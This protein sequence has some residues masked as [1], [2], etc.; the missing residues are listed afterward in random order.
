MDAKYVV[1]S[2]EPQRAADAIA[3]GQSIGNPDK[4]AKYETEKMWK[5][6]GAQ[7]TDIEST[8]DSN[9]I[10]TINYPN[11]IFTPGSLTHLLTV[12][13]GGQMDID[14]I[15]KCVLVELTFDEEIVSPYVGPKFGVNKVRESIEITERPMIGGIVK[16]KTGLDEDTLKKIVEEMIDGGVDFIKEDEILGEI[17]GLTFLKRIKFIDKLI[18]KKKSN[19]IYAPALN[20]SMSQLDN[21]IKELNRM[22]HIKAFHF[23]VWGGLDLFKYISDNTTKMS[24]YQKSG[25]KVITSGKFS[26][27]FEIWCVLCRLAGADMMHAGMVGGYLDEPVKLMKDRIQNM[28][29]EFYSLNGVIPSMSCG[30]HPGLVKYLNNLFGNNI[31]I[32]SGGAIHAHKDGTFAGTKSFLDAAKGITSKELDIAIEQ[33]GLKK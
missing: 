29:G 26:V 28:Q 31:M 20:V 3:V 10:V 23:N 24:F 16:P 25:D 33:F 22:E 8:D 30:A 7:V 27:S 6:Y 1:Y 5:E 4:R 2:K 15:E 9:V 14:L 21:A 12:L 32:S 19:V 13:M 18:E 11:R 17:N